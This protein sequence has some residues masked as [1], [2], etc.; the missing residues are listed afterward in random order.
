MPQGRPNVALRHERRSASFVAAC[1]ARAA[2]RLQRLIVIQASYD[3]Q[4]HA[5]EHLWPVTPHQGPGDIRGAALLES[6]SRA[7][8]RV[9]GGHGRRPRPG[10]VRTTD[11]ESRV[12]SWHVGGPGYS[13]SPSREESIGDVPRERG[14][15]SPDTPDTSSRSVVRKTRWPVASVLGS[16]LVSLARCPGCRLGCG[17]FSSRWPVGSTSIGAMLSTILTGRSFDCS[18]LFNRSHKES[19]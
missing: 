18:Q 13:G 19:R 7:P 11:R 9:R 8:E 3:P 5:R 15:A 10:C 2:R 6:V 4:I 14:S 16:P 12:P 17:S 1:C